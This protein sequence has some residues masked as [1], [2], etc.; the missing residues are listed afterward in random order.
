MP[1]EVEK[2]IEGCIK[3]D[4]A[5]Q[6]L[7]YK[8]LASKLMSVCIR[9]THSRQEAE[10]CLQD[11]FMKIF[12]SLA[13]FKHQGVIEAWA[14]KITVN[15]L[16]NYLEKNKKYKLHA[17]IDDNLEIEVLIYHQTNLIANE[18]LLSIIGRLPQMFKV[19]FNLHAIEGYSHKE[20]AEILNITEST[21]RSYLSRAKELLVK[22]HEKLNHI[23]NEKIAE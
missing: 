9:Y 21:S 5:S 22:M 20:I 6:Q 19:I 3:G 23:E 1:S 14:R 7:L 18:E 8:R 11:S 15:T 17:D 16:I 4:R 10:D 2:I 12:G 13:S